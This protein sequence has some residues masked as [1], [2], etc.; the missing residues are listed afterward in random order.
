MT[1]LSLGVA[2][3]IGRVDSDVPEEV[4]LGGLR[5]LG[6][7]NQVITDVVD[8]ITG[9]SRAHVYA[10]L[11]EVASWLVSRWWRL[12]FEARPPEDP[13]LA[14]RLA[15]DLRAA[16]SAHELPPLSLWGDG[17]SVHVSLVPSAGPSR[18]RYGRSAAFDVRGGDFDAALE[19][20]VHVVSERL[21]G[22]AAG[23]AELDALWD[24]LQGE[25]QNRRLALLCRLQARAGVDPG[26]RDDA[27]VDQL[28]ALA[29]S[30]G[31]V[32]GDELAAT[33]PMVGELRDVAATM[34]ALRT[35]PSNAALPIACAQ[36]VRVAVTAYEAPWRAGARAARALRQAV[37]LD[38]HEAISNPDLHGLLELRS[39]P[40]YDARFR[41]L[42]GG[43]RDGGQQ[44]RVAYP[45]TNPLGQRFF[46]ARL[47]GSACFAGTDD[48]LLAVT[49][50]YTA[51]QKA[52]RS[53]AIEFL[54][55][56]ER[57]DA[58]TN[59]VGVDEYGIELAA[60]HFQVSELAVHSALI[61][62]GKIQRAP[63]SS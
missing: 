39:S 63:A 51:Q 22:S 16:N 24:E 43:W 56:W 46:L 52:N 26:D 17:D 42:G 31:S 21:R 13:P 14:W 29:S 33:L 6:P 9:S 58:Y 15:H 48:H 38:D 62:H 28:A 41:Q 20:F 12:R 47:L 11:S 44:V 55:P 30:M 61:N 35:G 10:P 5:I 1:S 19:A 37:G 49:G 27:W 53:F 54:C 50:A 45:T 4:T 60:D 32:A 23:S 2:E 3:W 40:G 7:T 59:E 34:E 8:T 36:S 18:L 57:L 25:R